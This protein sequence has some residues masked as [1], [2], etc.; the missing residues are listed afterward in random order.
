MIGS[1][2]KISNTFS[3]LQMRSSLRAIRF[4]I[5]LCS[6]LLGTVLSFACAFLLN[7]IKNKVL[8]KAYQS[9][10]TLPHLISMVIVGYLGFAFLS[11]DTGFLN[12]TVLPWLGIEEGISVVYGK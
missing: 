11:P 7:E 4:F 3:R 8:L 5:I 9:I 1:D 2:S 10:I 12:K 6:L